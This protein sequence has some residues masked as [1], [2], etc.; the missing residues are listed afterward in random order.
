MALTLEVAYADAAALKHDAETQLGRGGLFVAVD[1]GGLPP[2]AELTLRLLL[3]GEGMEAA[4][5]LTVA[6]AE[7]ACVEIASAARAPLLAAVAACT[8]GVEARAGVKAARLYDAAAQRNDA[9][10]Q[11]NSATAQQHAGDPEAADTR[12][13]IPLE[14][15]I[16]AMSIGEKVQLALHGNREARALLM[17]ERAGVIQSSLVRNPKTTLDEVQALAR[18]PQLAPDTAELLAQHPTHGVSPQIALAL[19][20]NPRTP[21]PTATSMVARLS[22]GDLRV[23]AKGLGVRTQ[24]AAAARKRLFEPP[25]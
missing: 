22:P 4:A 2:L 13:Q 16:I 17:R 12:G 19:V 20:R 25:R 5:R 14:R 21:I 11:Q 6:T 1:A 10:A 15:R 9:V 24:V 7:A 8:A 23:V 3:D 18:A